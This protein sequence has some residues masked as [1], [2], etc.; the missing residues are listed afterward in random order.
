MSRG[1]RR[2]V[3]AI[4]LIALIAAG[5]YALQWQR[6]IDEIIRGDDTAGKRA[7]TVRLYFA[8]GDAQCLLAESRT[9]VIDAARRGGAAAGPS[10]RVVA[11]AALAALAAGPEADHLWPTIPNGAA[12]LD[13]ALEDGV[14]VVNY[15]EELRTNHGG[16]SAGEILTVGSIAGTVSELEGVHAVQLLLE[17]EPMETLSGH[18]SLIDPVRIAP[19][20]LSLGRICW[21]GIH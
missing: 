21:D 17:G 5:V 9:V 14:A 20:A 11:E 15:S 4:F 13:V 12:V 19:E 1:S 3:A 2:L 18:L 16:G 7:E 10:F 6:P 8:D